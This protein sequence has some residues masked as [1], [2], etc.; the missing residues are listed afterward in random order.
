MPVECFVGVSAA[1]RVRLLVMTG[2]RLAH[3][4]GAT[5][6]VLE[7]ELV[8]ASDFLRLGSSCHAAFAF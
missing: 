5:A 8:K 6:G 7:A 4:P 2:M 1:R 3:P